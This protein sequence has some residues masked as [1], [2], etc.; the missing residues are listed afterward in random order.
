M[1]KLLQL[2]GFVKKILENNNQV[3]F[4]WF[5]LVFLTL[6]SAVLNHSF[7]NFIIFKQS[8]FHLQQKLNLYNIYPNEY[9]DHYYYSPTFAILVAPFTVIPSIVGTFAW[10]LFDAGV[11]YFAIRKLPIRSFYQ[12]GVLL[13]SVHEMMNA[14]S[15]LQSNGIIAG[16]IILSFVLLLKQKEHSATLSL[17]LGFFIKLYGIVGLAFFFFS[18]QKFKYIAYLILWVI[19]LVLLP[20][21]IT[22]PEFLIQSYKDWF[23]SLSV[24][25]NFDLT[26]DMYKNGVDISIQGMIK[27][28][29]NLPALNKFYFIIP[30]LILFASQY[31]KIKYFNHLVY[32]LYILCS[33]MLFVIVF[34]T[35]SESPTYIIGVVPICLWYVLQ[36]KTTLVNTAFIIAIFFSSFSYSD[37]FTPWLRIHIMAPYA[38]KVVGCFLIWVVVLIQ[39]HTKQFLTIDQS[40]LIV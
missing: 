34:N 31:T 20:L 36:R 29:F 21:C 8:F 10:G 13:L 38:L 4:I 16:S 3:A 7:N 28:V 32:Q 14:S 25:S 5:G 23:A 27:R 17:L 11:L 6:L 12:N 9:W 1:G 18:N 39:I 35:G 2:K 22:S 26:I 30:G 24:K 15:N 40:K 19:V 33:V 37:L